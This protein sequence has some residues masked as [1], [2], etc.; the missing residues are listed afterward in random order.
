M[1]ITCGLCGEEIVVADDLADGQ[2]IRC[3][4]CEGKTEYRKPSRIE[5]PTGLNARRRSP[6]AKSQP[7]DAPSETKIMRS[8]FVPTEE[9]KPKLRV[10]RKEA[11]AQPMT[12]QQMV[13]RRLHMAEDHV[14]F[15][16]EM[17]DI[18]HRRK[19]RENINAALM[20]LVAVLCAAGIY[21][22]VGYRKEQRQRTEIALAEER[23]RVEAERVEQELKEKAR[24]VA[25]EKAAEEKRRAEEQRRRE[26]ADRIQAE[27]AKEANALQESKVLYRKACALLADGEFDFLKNLS[28]NAQPGKVPGE[29]Y[30]LL[31][32]LD[33]G[34]IVVCQSSTNG[35]ESVFRLDETGKKTPFDA[36]TFLSSL[37]GK[38]YLVAHDGR[39]Y[40]HSKRKKAH[41]APISKAEVVDLSKEFFGDIASEAGRIGFDSDELKFE[42]VFIPRDSKKVIIA[43]TVEYGVPYSLS[44]VREAIE[45]AFPM[46]KVTSSVSPMKKKFKRTV[47]FWDGARVKRG[48][49]GITYV[50]RVAPPVTYSR[51]TTYG[52]GW[53]YDRNYW[54]IAERRRERAEYNRA[55][56]QTL[57]DEAIKQD[58]AERLFHAQHAASKEERRQA[59]LSQAER[60]YVEK[61]D[62]IYAAGTLYFR[63]KIV[64][65]C[66]PSAQKK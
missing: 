7:K 58:E 61:I 66:D 4:Y 18:E 23:N 37:D 20:L 21:W 60:A 6:D 53:H 22:Y 63:A 28:T 27:K 50:P 15:Y 3:P 34:E 24:R 51:V 19:M 48:V 39:V 57:H 32:F 17:K 44:S 14:R 65:G 16:E 36:D 33:N 43:D 64:N 8:G 42:I 1:K 62:R 29:F 35:I 5:L 2:H 13:S 25:E 49:D 45:D 26:E 30:Y 54:H 59:A 56:W 46:R 31:P 40:F 47:V 10:I 9:Q 41:V 52:P 11:E 12:E 38:D 55:H